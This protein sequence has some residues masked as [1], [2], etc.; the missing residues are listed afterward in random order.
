LGSERLIIIIPAASS[1]KENDI[2]QMPNL[3][4]HESMICGLA[5][6]EPMEIK[7]TTMCRVFV[8]AKVEARKEPEKQWACTVDTVEV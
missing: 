6:E 5:L 1:P 2:M 4:G 3:V 8:L 7:R